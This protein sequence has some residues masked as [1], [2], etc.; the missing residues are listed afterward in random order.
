ML[1]VEK[2][3]KT[4]PSFSLKDVS[5]KLDAGCIMGFIGVNGAGKTTT[6]KSILNIVRPDGGSVRFCG[7]DVYTDEAAFKRETGFMFGTIDYYTKTKVK[8]VTGVFSRFFDAWDE[9]AFRGFLE[10][11]NID[12]NKK[13]GELSAGM[14]VK[15]GLAMT[16]SHGA[17]LLILDEPTSGLDPVA[18]DEFL[19]LLQEIVADGSKSVLFSTHITTDLDKCAG[20]II[21][22]R[23]G[24]LIADDTKDGLLEKHILVSGKTGELSEDLKDAM[25]CWKINNPVSSS[26]NALINDSALNESTFTG[27]MLKERLSA[28]GALVV[29]QPNL[30]DL[31]V[32]YNR[33]QAK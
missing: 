29:E 22:I 4:Y 18:R 24:L 8:K 27:L 1:E 13:I 26:K 9:A 2:L 6:L 32:Y 3:C 28:P 30:E 7:R 16:L 20:R 14:R 33:E 21:F 11:F 25:I 23:N 19:D 31:M 5:F 15:L 17:K 12:V 10:R